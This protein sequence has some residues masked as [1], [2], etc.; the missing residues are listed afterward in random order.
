MRRV[1]NDGLNR[2]VFGKS[3]VMSV[4]DDTT[5][6]INDLFV[7]MFFCSKRSVFLVL[8]NLEID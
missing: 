7:V 3:F 6:G 5:P 4:S 2:D 1:C 8:D